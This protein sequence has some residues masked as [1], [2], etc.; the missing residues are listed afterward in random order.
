MAE[1]MNKIFIAIIAIAVAA[2]ATKMFTSE[3]PKSKALPVLVK[4]EYMQFPLVSIKKLNRNSAIYRF[5]LPTDEHV[6]G[7]PI[8]QHITIKAHI[9]GSEVV[10]SYTPI[11]LDS[12][13]KGYFELLIKSYEQGKISKMFTSLKIGDTIDVQGPKGF[14]EYTDRS[15]KHLA[16]IA[17]GSGLTPMYQII[18]SIAENPKDKTK[19][20]FIYGNVE[21][22]DILLRDDLDKFAASKPGQIT[23]HYLLDKPSENWKGG[24][25][26]VT[27]ELMKEKLPAPADGVQ[28]L[29]CGPLPMV[30][31]IKR[32]AVALGFP[33][34]KPVSKMNDQVFVF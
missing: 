29:V 21:E 3:E 11:S 20:T 1:S 33:K 12:E 4:G 8:G 6:L 13:A 2:A 10:R 17:G 18:K 28:L 26:Y 27:P 25:G 9:D 23:I 31:A 19:V 14:Y 32:S 15:S 16:M 5:K 34:A 7:L 24:S 22:I 30:S